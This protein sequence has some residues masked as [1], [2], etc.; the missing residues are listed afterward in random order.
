MND[1]QRLAQFI[2]L[3]KRVYERM[4]RDG[5]WPWAGT[6]DSTEAD[7]LVESEDNSPNI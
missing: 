2:E 5:S 6:S 3:C 4:E 7:D 1:D